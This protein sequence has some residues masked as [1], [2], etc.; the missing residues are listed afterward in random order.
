MKVLILTCDKNSHLVR[1]FLRFYK[2]YWPDNPYKT[3]ILTQTKEIKTVH[4]VFY[5]G[6]SSWSSE[7]LKYLRQSKE[8]KLILI[9]EDHIIRQ[10]VDTKRVKIAEGLCEGDFGC[11]RLNHAPKKYFDR[12]TIKTDIKGF[13]EYPI[14]RR[15]SWTFQMAFW[16]KQYLFDVMREGEASWEHE[17][18][19][20]ARL[21]EMK[22]HWR[23]LWPEINI[24]DYPPRGLLK[25]GI[26]EP[27]A[28][29]WVKSQLPKNSRE[30][31]ILEDQIRG[32]KER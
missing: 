6:E 3:E 5:A 10:A 4:K 13:R 28:L 18:K 14:D 30:Y 21:K 22:T 26:L 12:H 23:I 15:F 7:L 1:V 11:V 16:Q 25:K 19:G 2:R 32:Q 20:I 29:K 31:K 17:E 9:H 27:P 24:I 8:D